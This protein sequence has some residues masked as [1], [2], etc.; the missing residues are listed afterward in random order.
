MTNFIEL[1]ELIDETNEKNISSKKNISG[2]SI[3]K[4]FFNT[5]GNIIGT[6]LT[7]YKIVKKN[8][9]ALN[10]MHLGRDKVLPI[11]LNN[12]ENELIVS[13]AY[14]VFRIKKEKK[15]IIP[16]Y[17]N[18][19]FQSQHF[20]KHAWF[21][22]D[23]SVRG[24]LDW[25]DFCSIKVFLPDLKKQK[26]IISIVNLF[27]KKISNNKKLLDLVKNLLQLNY[28]KWFEKYEFPTNK[29]NLDK[30]EKSYKSLNDK[31]YYDEELDTKVPNNWKY[32]KIG[33][34]E[35]DISDGNYSSLYPT[36]EDFKNN[37]VPFI[38]ASDLENNYIN[39]FKLRFISKEKHD[40]LKKGQ[41]KEGDILITNRGEIGNYSFVSKYYSDCNINSQIVRLNGNE[42]F[43]SIF[44]GCYLNS[45]FFKDQIFSDK[46]GT[47]LSQ[48]TIED[49]KDLKIIVPPKEI[50]ENF[51]ESF[52]YLL[53]FFISKSEEN[54]S[55][56]KNKKYILENLDK[57]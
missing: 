51:V 30:E 46:T 4:H 32:Q 15:E 54:I 52:D 17:L 47:A 29:K 2:I 13:P 22:T 38:R 37:G 44:I 24:G 49:L 14:K 25:K 31:F 34:I 28:S 16:E 1:S 19:C 57:I 33:D 55:L 20:D 36:N 39:P 35:L 18:L 27:N 21:Y 8:N 50:L 45:K 48:L 10:A 26:S 3:N 5:V 6:D 56:I 9:F 41:T 43:P 12:S 42:K 40:K 53:K 23:R 11:E 7:K